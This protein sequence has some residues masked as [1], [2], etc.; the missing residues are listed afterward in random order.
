MAKSKLLKLFLPATLIA[1]VPL[2]L[3]SCKK[4]DV[5]DFHIYGPKESQLYSL[6]ITSSIELSNPLLLLIVLICS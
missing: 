4:E 2:I 6:L 1:T 3:T 5:Y